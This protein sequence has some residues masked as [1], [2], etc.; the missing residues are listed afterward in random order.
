MKKREFL[1]PDL[2]PL[3]D[4]VFL[5][6]IF[7]LV[8]SAFKKEELALI[9]NLPVSQEAEE[10]VK[11]KELSIEL[12]NENIAFN[13]TVITFETLDQLLLK[14][15]YNKELVNIR[16]DENVQYK[17]IVKLLDILKKYNL[18]NIALISDVAPVTVE[19]P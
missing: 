1:T 18:E 8:S 13:G 19:T 6:L 2:T 16:I 7:F 15:K 3:I 12:S 14:S 4:V 17:R 5:L 9:L 11:H 10:Q